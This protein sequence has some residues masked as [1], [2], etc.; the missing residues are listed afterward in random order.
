MAFA[1]LKKPKDRN[2]LIT[3]GLSLPPVNALYADCLLIFLFFFFS[4]QLPQGIYR[5]Y[6]ARRCPSFADSIRLFSKTL[7]LSGSS[8]MAST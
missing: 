5:A 2:D 3:L 7:G 4:E 6:P 1:G 8:L